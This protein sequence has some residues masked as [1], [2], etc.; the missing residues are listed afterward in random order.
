MFKKISTV[1]IL[2][3]IVVCAVACGSNNSADASFIMF[4]SDCSLKLYGADAKETLQDVRAIINDIDDQVNVFKTYS[5]V[6]KINH[7]DIGVATPVREHTLS[8]LKKSK[9]IYDLTDKAFNPCMRKLSDLWGF[10]AEFSGEH[11]VPSDE[12][13]NALLPY[14]SF[15]YV[16]IDEVNKTVTRLDTR[17]ELD[18]GGIAKGYA[19]DKAAAV[20]RERNITK[21][22]INLGGNIYVIGSAN[23]GISKVSG[24]G[25]FATVTVTDN[26]IQTSG[27]Y[28]RYFEL[29]GRKYCHIL[30]RNGKSVEGDLRAVT[31]MGAS[32]ATCDALATA[33]MV[34]GVS[35]L[36]KYLNDS[37]IE[38]L[39]IDK[40]LTCTVR[41]F[42]GIKIVDG[43]Y[44][45]S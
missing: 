22:I 35:A 45:L 44:K 2:I 17:V 5:D 39:T 33:V 43:A 6:Y 3:A 18:F 28:E 7:S 14:A 37:E 21:A 38:Y 10:S 32:S 25:Y 24:S 26:S 40:D 20:C 29:D 30:D 1:I 9:A 27:D 19:C 4:S 16:V 15:D 23:I 13:I 34:D 36:D 8:L 12:E 42:N 31:L 41:G 11:K